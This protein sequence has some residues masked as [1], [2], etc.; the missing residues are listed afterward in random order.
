LLVTH[1][2]IK[3]AV[4]SKKFGKTLQTK[5]NKRKKNKRKKI[6]KKLLF[7]DEGEVNKDPLTSERN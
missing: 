3:N 4:N 5:K 1:R 6:N 2:T 7:L